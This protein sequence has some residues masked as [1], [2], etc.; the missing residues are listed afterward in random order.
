M[1]ISRTIVAISLDH[2]RLCAVSAAL[3]SGRAQVKGWLSAK[4]PHGVDAKDP[5]ATGQW[6][7]T[8][9]DKAGLPRGKLVIAVPRG[10]VA[11]KRLKLPKG[12]GMG[13][14]ELAGMVRLQMT[15]QLTMAV[16]GTAIDYVPIGGA[17]A[18]SVGAGEAPADGLPAGASVSV[19]AGALPGDRMQW[20]EA[21]AKAAGCKIERLGLRA[22][23]VAALLAAVSQRHSGPVLGI[24]AGWGSIEFVIVG[25]GQLV[26]ARAADGGL[27]GGPDGPDGAFTQRAAVEAKRT[28]MSYRAAEGSAEV[29]A[30]VVPGEGPLATELAQRCGEALEMTWQVAALPGVIELPEKMNESDRLVAAPLIGLVAEEILARPTLDFANPRKAPDL[31]AKKRQRVL[32]AVL[33]LIV[34]SGFGYYFANKSLGDLK[35]RLKS[36]TT[37]NLRLKT[38]YDAFLRDDARLKHLRQW[39]AAKADWLAHTK[40]LSDQMPDPRQANLD[41]ISGNLQANVAFA[42]GQNGTYNTDGW[43]LKQVAAIGIKGP[44]KQREVGNDLRDRLIS[45]GIYNVD[46]KGADDASRFEF[47]LTTAKPTPETP[48]PPSAAAPKVAKGGGK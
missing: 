33:G 19:L 46:T 21:L 40:W 36:A 11:L 47:D 12:E 31:A 18:E 35:S 23:G 15:R 42:P 3:S 38:E 13:E 1:S 4:V 39:T 9:L 17:A 44:I 5:A 28:W 20:Y 2:D 41:Q 37:E 34:L 30:V 25:D 6:L 29:D 45:S 10:E 43:S 27:A 32:A 22:A 48:A 14:M 8:E 24:A 26:F 16:E 7:A